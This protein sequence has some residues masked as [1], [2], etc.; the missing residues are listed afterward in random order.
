MLSG[1]ELYPRWVPLMRILHSNGF[2]YYSKNFFQH[3]TASW[4]LPFATIIFFTV[5]KKVLCM[6]QG[7]GEESVLRLLGLWLY[8]PA[9]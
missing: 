8:E 3:L 1:F 2:K 5:N 6:Y 4:S 9:I 7:S